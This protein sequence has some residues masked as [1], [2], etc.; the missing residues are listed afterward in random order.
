[1]NR[2]L[3]QKRVS[4]TKFINIFNK[5]CEITTNNTSRLF[6]LWIIWFF[7]LRL[8]EFWIHCWLESKFWIID[9]PFFG[10]CYCH[11]VSRCTKLL[12]LCCQYKYQYQLVLSLCPLCSSPA[13]TSE[14]FNAYFPNFNQFIKRKTSLDKNFWLGTRSA[15]ACTVYTLKYTHVLPKI[16]YLPNIWKHVRVFA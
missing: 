14:D 7:V 12:Y 16:I 9:R 10:E 1:M 3:E 13:I 4:I 15:D 2:T 6:S 11:Y 5:S 8:E